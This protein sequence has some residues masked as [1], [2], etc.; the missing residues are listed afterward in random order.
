MGEKGQ[1][2]S[3]QRFILVI[4]DAAEDGDSPLHVRLRIVVKR[5]LRS[6]GFRCVEVRE[7]E[8]TTHGHAGGHGG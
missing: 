6:W 5:L 1:V 7:A 4:D 3:R 2:K 8:P